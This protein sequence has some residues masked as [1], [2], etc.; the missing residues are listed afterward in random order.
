MLEDRKAPVILQFFYLN[1]SHVINEMNKIRN[2]AKF[3]T[4][5]KQ[6]D[7]VKHGQCKITKYKYNNVQW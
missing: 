6:V 2:F 5:A 3:F 4:Q 7:C 1:K